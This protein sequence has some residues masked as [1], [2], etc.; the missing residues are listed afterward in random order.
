MLGLAACDRTGQPPE[1]ETARVPALV[2]H[3]G[4]GTLLRE[5][6]SEQEEREYNEALAAALEAGYSVL[7][8]GGSAVDAV[9]TTLRLME[10]SP[11]FNAGKGA[12]F[13]AEGR[14]ELDA[15]IMDGSSMEA[16]AVAG[17][18]T[19]KHPITAARAV[20][21]QTQHVLLAGEGADGF[22][23]SVGI[24]TVDPAYFFTERRWQAMQRA[25]ARDQES[26]AAVTGAGGGGGGHFG[27]VGA[28]A[29]DNEG[30]L[31]AGT[32]TG[33]MTY[34]KH[35]RVGDSPIIG[36]GTYANAGCAISATG[37][38]EFFIRYAVAHDICARLRD[39]DLSIEEAAQQ[40]VMGVLVEAGG[41][42]GVIALDH[43]GNPALVFNSSG[44][45]RG[46]ILG[47]GEPH[48]AIYR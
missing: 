2:I 31:A 26:S 3:G 6:I 11:L 8:A 18:T 15:A 46:W 21:E 37:H 12:V 27:T 44:M 13:T 20:M 43:L 40:V 47:D 5:N 23:R 38:G 39:S 29:L 22:A 28:V 34:K 30:R 9:E 24:E 17:V 33:G 14:N 4:A 16:G 45:Y 42:G 35:G 1:V 10:D 32:S 48:T 7:T 36:A 19:I 41:E 25:L